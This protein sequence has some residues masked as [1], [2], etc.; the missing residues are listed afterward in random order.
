M[1]A[2]CAGRVLEPRCDV[3]VRSLGLSD[4]LGTWNAMR[5]F[6]ADRKPDSVDEIWLLE[7]E[8]VFTLGQAGRPEHVLDAGDIPLVHSDRGGQVTYHGPGQLI[9][10]VLVNLQ[11]K[12]LGVRHLVSALEQSVIDLLAVAGVTGSRRAG[13]PGIYVDERKVSA[14]GLRVRRGCS[15]HGLALNVD[16]DLSPFK[17]IDPCGYPELEVTQLADLG[18]RWDTLDAAER[19][20]EQI[21]RILGF[22]GNIVRVDGGS[23]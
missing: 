9:A 2:R 1:I 11:R 10:Y 15:Y 13:A 8:P 3:I 4:Y 17:R 21:T 23:C 5:R 18:V 12:R 16:M 6:T 20:Q 22:D 19:L 14:L 7:H